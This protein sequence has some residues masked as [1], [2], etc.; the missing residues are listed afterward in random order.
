MVVVGGDFDGFLKWVLV[1]GMVVA[2]VVVVVAGRWCVG[3]AR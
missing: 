2:I 3:F 1:V